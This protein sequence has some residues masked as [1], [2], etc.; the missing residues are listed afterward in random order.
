MKVDPSTGA[1][2]DGQWIDGST[3]GA[4]GITLAGG[5]VW[6]T[7]PTAAP[8][9][10]FLPAVLAPENLGP[11]FLEGAYLSAVDFSGGVNTGP[12]IACVLDGGNLS[13]V[14]AVSSFRLISIFGAHLGPA[15]GCCGAEWKRFIHR[16]SVHHFRRQS[17][18]VAVRFCVADQ[19]RGTVASVVSVRNLAASDND[20]AGKGERL[21]IETSISVRCIQFERVRRFVRKRNLLARMVPPPLG[22]GPLR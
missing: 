2:E 7:G 16:R 12:A 1:V 18:P 19:P 20:H 3:P 8:D 11:G 14:G 21:P 22:F 5:K 4:T 10:P 9:V 6:I 17:R 13:H 15:V